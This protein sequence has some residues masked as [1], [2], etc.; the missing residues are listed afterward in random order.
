MSIFEPDNNLGGVTK[1]DS[2]WRIIED[3]EPRDKEKSEKPELRIFAFILI[4]IVFIFTNRLAFLQITQ[5][6][7]NSLQAQGNRI[8]SQVIQP[9]RG[10]ITDRFG[11]V[12]AKNVA[13]FAVEI[14]PIDLP[15]N[16]DERMSTYNAL[17]QRFN[18]KTDDL[19]ASIEKSG[20][21]SVNPVIIAENIAHDEAI[22]LKLEFKDLPGLRVI[23]RPIREYAKLPGLGHLLG[24]TG[25]VGPE[26]LKPG[27]RYNLQS[28][29][30]KTG[31]EE[32]YE[33]ELHGFPG[34]EQVEVDSQGYYQRTL[35]KRDPTPG[36]NVS[37]AINLGLQTKLGAELK[38]M[39]KEKKSPSGVAI[40]MD[41]NNGQIKAMVSL[42]DYD[43]NEF[44]QGI[45]PERYQQLLSD[46]RKLFTNRAIAGVYPSGS[47]IKPVM[48]AAGLAEGVISANTT[49]DAPAAISIGQFIFPDWKRHGIVDVKRAL[50]VSS[51]VFFYAV[52]G[53]WGD[54]PG[55]GVSRIAKYLHLFGFGANSGVDL[56]GEAGGLV[57][58]EEWKKQVKNEP[59]YIGD[60]Y[61]LAIGQGDLL[62]TPLQ[63]A[64]AT[65]TIANGGYPYEPQLILKTYISGTDLQEH[66]YEQKKP[67][68]ILD[69]GVI[70]VVRQ[71]MRE[72]VEY[73]SA[74][75]L[76]ELPVTSAG[77]TGTAQFGTEDKTHSWF[78]AFAPYNNPEIA[79]TV[80][81][82]AGGGG[83]EAA[84]PV[85]LETM[86][87]Y[88]KQ[89]P[90]KR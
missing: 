64:R 52:G 15:R 28:I 54:I 11:E 25:K 14:M 22:N 2:E 20:L 75:R 39:L 55:L 3:D 43:N 66:P 59:W 41:P 10:I 63:M 61:H 51:N 45:K 87:W 60:T 27:A 24:Y 56:A 62:V 19:I 13:A 65:S 50:A 74:R 1:G 77:K 49:I 70:E 57:P 9:P 80:L 58:D 81:V 68:R 34:V 83:H 31:I 37:L 71:G 33:E 89:Q 21:R 35:S 82:E 44:A 90:D 30:G 86:K 29:V 38:K 67:E 6:A 76:Q 32:S 26:D 4:L 48:A 42:P 16:K 8:R 40:V 18:L 17:A 69:S 23:E 88:F 53:G 12:L 72:A 85:A 7:D 47:V 84:L 73:G 36:K 78:T 5:G 46:E 79:I